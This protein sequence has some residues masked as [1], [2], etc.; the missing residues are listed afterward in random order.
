MG[1]VFSCL[2][3]LDISSTPCAFCPLA[4]VEGLPFR[5]VENGRADFFSPSSTQ[6]VAVRKRFTTVFFFNYFFNGTLAGV[7]S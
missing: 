7:S 1:I 4:S 2:L 6:A 5:D 3:E